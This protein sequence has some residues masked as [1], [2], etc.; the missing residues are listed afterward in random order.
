RWPSSRR[1]SRNSIPPKRCGA[2]STPGQESTAVAIF[3]PVDSGMFASLRRRRPAH[4]TQLVLIQ[5]SMT[6]RSSFDA[7]V[8][9]G[10]HNG[11]VAATLLGRAGRSVLVLERRDQLGGAA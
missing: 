2:A 5:W 10:G 7:V 3:S 6:E 9:G 1:P 4:Q 8:V 11:L